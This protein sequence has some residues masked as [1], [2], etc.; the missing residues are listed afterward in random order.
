M[1]LANNA[2]SLS[3]LMHVSLQI[4]A[5]T[6]RGRAK[7]GLRTLLSLGVHEFSWLVASPD[8]EINIITGE[9]VCIE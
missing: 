6:T 5:H 1:S 8:V 2:T 3:E 4:F 7:M 9:A